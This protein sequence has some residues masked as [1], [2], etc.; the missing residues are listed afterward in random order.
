M[1]RVKAKHAALQEQATTLPCNVAMETTHFTGP[2]KENGDLD[3][4]AIINDRHG[5]R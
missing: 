5:Q 1:E 2:L 4:F 3:F